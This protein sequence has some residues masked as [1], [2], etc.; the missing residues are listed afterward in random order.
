MHFGYLEK[1]GDSSLC[2]TPPCSDPT[3]ANSPQRNKNQTRT[4]ERWGALVTKEQQVINLI[5]K[6][7]TDLHET[8][9]QWDHG[10]ML[11]HHPRGV[12][13]SGAPEEHSVHSTRLP[14]PFL[15]SLDHFTQ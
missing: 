14:S 12:R 13:A 10:H 5:L 15:S 4:T 7:S 8:A 2:N 3:R 1:E 6:V 9:T 11:K